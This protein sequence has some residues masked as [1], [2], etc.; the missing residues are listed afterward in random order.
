MVTVAFVD[1]MPGEDT[2]RLQPYLRSS[3]DN[4][5]WTGRPHI[6]TFVDH[7]AVRPDRPR[8]HAEPPRIFDVPTRRSLRTSGLCADR[9]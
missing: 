9:S 2:V 3:A 7:R 4:F 5:D 6:Q 1:N 8:R